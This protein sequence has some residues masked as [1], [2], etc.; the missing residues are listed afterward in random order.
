MIWSS[1]PAYNEESLRGL[2][3]CWIRDRENIPEKQ[4]IPR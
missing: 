3:V 4:L 1:W 2:A